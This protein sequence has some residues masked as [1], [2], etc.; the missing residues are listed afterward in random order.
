MREAGDVADLGNE[1]R[2]E[3]GT[4]AVHLHDGR[5]FRKLRRRLVHLDPKGL[6]RFGSGVQHGNGLPNQQLGVVVLGKYGDE[7]GRAAVDF[8]CFLHAEVVLLP[9][10]PVP[11]M[12]HEGVKR[13]A[14][15]TVHMPVGVDKV[16]T[17]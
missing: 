7:V 9:L 14:S 11:V 4:D 13:L 5:V 12:L 3:R 10:A 1:L 15:D 8:L 16:L 2:A 17:A 6:N